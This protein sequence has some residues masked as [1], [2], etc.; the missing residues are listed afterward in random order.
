VRVRFEIDVQ[1]SAASF[2]PSRFEGENLGVLHPTVSVS[3]GADKVAVSVS[4][5]RA[6]V[7][8]GRSQA[9]GFA[10][11]FKSAVKNSFVGGVSG[12]SGRNLTRIFGLCRVFTTKAKP[13]RDLKKGR[14]GRKE[15]LSAY[16]FRAGKLLYESSSIS[17]TAAPLRPLGPRRT[18]AIE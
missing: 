7:R 15:K 6:D 3:S 9:D 16:L 14:E 12:H 17:A 2:A 8:V 13:L 5:D 1:S 18:G 10:R 11:Q 4:N